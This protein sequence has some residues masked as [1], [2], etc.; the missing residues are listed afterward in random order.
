MP[1]IQR[2]NAIHKEFSVWQ[3]MELTWSNVFLILSKCEIKSAKL[4]GYQRLTTIIDEAASSLQSEITM[5]NTL[6]NKY[7]STWK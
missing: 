1:S 5:L 7:I 3:T 4:K 6:M 2:W